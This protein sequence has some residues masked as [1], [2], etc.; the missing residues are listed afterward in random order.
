MAAILKL[1]LFLFVGAVACFCAPVFFSTTNGLWYAGVPLVGFAFLLAALR[2]R[3]GVI[4]AFQLLI[5]G[6]LGYWLFYLLLVFAR[7]V[8]RGSSDIGG[9]DPLVGTAIF[10]TIGLILATVFEA[11]E[12][13]CAL[14]ETDRRRA[15][16]GLVA[17]VLQVA[18]TVR[19]A[20][21]VA[22]V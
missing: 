20:I 10:W 22:Q 5:I 14:W 1:Q 18:L 12:F 21:L 2:G 8:V 15:A 11:V 6:N 4:L 13:V 3:N 16:A 9:I 17:V 19:S 7:P